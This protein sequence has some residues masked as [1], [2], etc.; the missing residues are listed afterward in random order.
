[1]KKAEVGEID[2]EEAAAMVALAVKTAV[3]KLGGEE[4][5]KV[6]ITDHSL[7]QQTIKDVLSEDAFA[8]YSAHRAERETFHQQVLRDMAVACMDTQLLLDDTQREVLE[9]AA[10]RLV[11]G[12]LREE[13]PAEFMFFQLFLQTVN[14][15]TLTFWQQGE[16]ERVFGPIMWGI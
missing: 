12:P 11:P 13:K 7:Y 4:D 15:E 3:D 9:T 10:S 1:M 14:F 5:I 8:Q 2:R 6:D 16:F